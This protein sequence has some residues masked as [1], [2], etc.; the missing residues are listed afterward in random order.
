MNRTI[1]TTLLLGVIIN[2]HSNAK[3]SKADQEQRFLTDVRQL[4]FDGLR[5]GEGYF[6]ADGSKLIFQSE[7]HQGN[8]FLPNLPYGL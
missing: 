3:P 7:R 4:T 6:S 5:S 1:Y 2:S 8:P